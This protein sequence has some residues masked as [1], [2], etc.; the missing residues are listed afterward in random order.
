V[1][2]TIQQNAFEPAELLGI[3]PLDPLLSGA[4]E[5]WSHASSDQREE[6]EHHFLRGQQLMRLGKVEEAAVEFG[7]CR[8]I[9]L[10][11]QPPARELLKCFLH[12]GATVDRSYFAKAQKEASLVERQENLDPETKLILAQTYAF[13]NEMEKALK[14][15]FDLESCGALELAARAYQTFGYLKGSLREAESDF[16]KSVMLIEQSD[17][18]SPLLAGLHANVARLHFD[19][20]DFEGAKRHLLE[21]ASRGSLGLDAHDMLWICCYK[22]GQPFPKKLPFERKNHDD[23]SLPL[24]ELP[25]SVAQRL[26]SEKLAGH[27]F[28]LQ[29]SADNHYNFS[30]QILINQRE[31]DFQ[32]DYKH[33][34][35]RGFG[36]INLLDGASQNWV[37][38]VVDSSSPEH[39]FAEAFFALDAL[40]ENDLKTATK[41]I[42]NR[43]PI[44]PGVNASILEVVNDA[45]APDRYICDPTTV[46][47][48]L[49]GNATLKSVQRFELG[50]FPSESGLEAQAFAVPVLDY[51]EGKFTV[52][53]LL[54]KK[55]G[56]FFTQECEAR[57]ETAVPLQKIPEEI[58][59]LCSHLVAKYGI[60]P[61]SDD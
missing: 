42:A 17:K 15:A 41:L 12:L 19:S 55:A 18:N 13:T 32:F 27:D 6:S 61:P 35:A 16:E 60:V 23:L 45:L 10:N 21:A 26:A 58:S 5:P 39:I 3:A 36:S 29:R 53:L 47:V 14:F 54:L 33:K 46:D 20:R 59:L 44:A 1:P 25:L 52:G 38:F 4:I 49:M 48:A 34:P 22:T 28:K 40:R 57:R 50:L 30:T 24:A 2:E 8:A 43:F 31:V 51:S 37:S 7:C 11:D 9:D 56:G